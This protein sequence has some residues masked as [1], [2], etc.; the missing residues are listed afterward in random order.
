MPLSDCL[1]QSQPQ[2]GWSRKAAEQEVAKYSSYQ[3]VKVVKTKF[4]S[5]MQMRPDKIFFVLPFIYLWQ[6]K[7]D[8]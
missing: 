7:S 3:D 2:E 8:C 5:F 1:Q 4:A 6:A